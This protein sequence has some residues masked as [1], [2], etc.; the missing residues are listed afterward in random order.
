MKII[1]MILIL[2]VISLS[3]CV[4]YPIILWVPRYVILGDHETP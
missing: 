3:G 2:L 4:V 1:L